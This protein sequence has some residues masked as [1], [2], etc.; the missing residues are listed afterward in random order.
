[1]INKDMR[2]TCAN[3]KVILSLNSQLSRGLMDNE[4][5]FWSDDRGSILE[6]GIYF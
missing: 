4:M 2:D 3:I 6:F 1:M 5:R